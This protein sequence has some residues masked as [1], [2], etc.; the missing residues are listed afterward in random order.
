MTKTNI[1]PIPSTSQHHDPPNNKTHIIKCRVTA[2]EKASL[3]L[4]GK[5][6]NLSLIH[7]W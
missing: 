2:E 3:E 4:T 7:I 5:L 6:L 1:H